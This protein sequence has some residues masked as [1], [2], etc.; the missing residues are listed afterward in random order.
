MENNDNKKEILDYWPFDYP[1]R[2]NQIVA[3]EWAAEQTAKYLILEAPVGSGKSN[4]GIT[5]SRYLGQRTANGDAFILTPQRILQKQYDDSFSD[6]EDVNLLPLYGK[7]NYNCDSKNASCEVGSVVR[8]RCSDCPHS[9]AKARAKLASNTVLNYKL[10]LTAFD[11]TDMFSPRKLMVMDECHTLESHLVDFDAVKVQEWFSKKYDLPFK[12]QSDLS[13]AIQW[14]K[15]YYTDAIN[16][17]LTELESDVAPLLDKMGS[18]LSRRDVKFIQEVESFGSHVDEVSMLILKTDEYIGE[19]FVLVNDLLSFQFKRLTGSYSFNRIMKPKGQ[20]FLFMS[21]TVL[22]K[23]GFCR[24]LGIPPEETAFLSL[25]SD[26]PI[27]NRPVFYMPQ[28]KMNYKWNNPENSASREQMLET[29]TMLLAAHET[30]SGIIHTA[31]F[32]IAS[33]LAKHL[34]GNT[35]QKIF[36]HNPES[37]LDRNAVIDNFLEYKKPGVLISPSSTEGLDLKYKLGNFAIFVKVPYGYLGDQWIKKRMD[38]SNEWYRRQAMINII[39]GGGRI[40]RAEDDAGSVYIL[41]GS[42]RYL[43]QQSKNIV[44]QW[45]LDAYETV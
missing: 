41:D 29:V 12:K 20:R 23:D 31:N 5:L 28:M 30:E 15:D 8:P 16:N 40:V 13:S 26:F 36:Q 18:E 35:A 38:M 39:Q 10:A 11:F 32:A 2:Q 25:D 44:P 1:P 42:F 7:S 9:K 4:I 45:W 33:W 27:A 21:S 14:M 37:E 24:D 17:K 3:L 19:H 22:D 6:N 34:E 43:L